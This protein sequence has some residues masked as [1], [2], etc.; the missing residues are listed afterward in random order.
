M[1]Q[2]EEKTIAAGFTR[3]EDLRLLF[4]VVFEF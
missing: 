2:S 1:L 4:V 3:L